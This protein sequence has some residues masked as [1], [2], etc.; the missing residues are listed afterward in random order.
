MVDKFCLHLGPEPLIKRMV[1]HEN[2]KIEVNAIFNNLLHLEVDQRRY[3]LWPVGFLNSANLLHQLVLFMFAKHL[4]VILRLHYLSHDGHQQ[5]EAHDSEDLKD[6]W[7]QVLDL[8]PASVVAV[9]HSGNHLEDPVKAKH[10][11][12]KMTLLLKPFRINYPG[13]MVIPKQVLVAHIDPQTDSVMSEA[14]NNNEKVD[15]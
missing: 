8:G 12:L 2:T 15:E 5:R 9:P 1:F 7:N 3:K 6:D 11:Q 14:P 13:R 10:V 4:V